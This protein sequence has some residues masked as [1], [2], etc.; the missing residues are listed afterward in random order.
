MK[1]WMTPTFVPKTHEPEKNADVWKIAA[2]EM[3]K[4][5]ADTPQSMK[6]MTKNTK[7]KIKG[8]IRVYEMEL[9]LDEF[10]KSFFPL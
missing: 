7:E 9:K 1:L 10:K 8:F 2:F 5:V 6:S 4:L 3:V